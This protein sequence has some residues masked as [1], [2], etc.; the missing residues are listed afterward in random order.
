MLGLRYV[1]GL[2]LATPRPALSMAASPWE[3]DPADQAFV[4]WGAGHTR[5]ISSGKAHRLCALPWHVGSVP[6]PLVH[7]VPAPCP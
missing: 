7:T 5:M 1:D 2:G 6:S 4:P 3:A